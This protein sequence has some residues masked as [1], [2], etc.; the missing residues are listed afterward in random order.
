M[1]KPVTAYV[2]DYIHT[3]LALYLRGA[4]LVGLEVVAR[5][6][7]KS[8]DCDGDR[9]SDIWAV[10]DCAN[11]LCS[12]KKKFFFYEAGLRAPDWGSRLAHTRACVNMARASDVAVV[13][14][15][16]P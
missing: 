2:I 15:P 7:C 10:A 9:T 14:A 4:P 12:A 6:G 5:L 13:V 1:N 3:S 8:G 16:L 11:I